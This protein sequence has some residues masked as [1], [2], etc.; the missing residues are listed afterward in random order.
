MELDLVDPIP[1]PIVGP[2]HGRV[3]VGLHSEPQRPST[4]GRPEPVQAFESPRPALPLDRLAENGVL[5]EE[6]IALEWRW[7]VLNLVR[8][9][10]A[11]DQ[12]HGG[13]LAP[14]NT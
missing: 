12:R 13:R 3:L 2:E 8:A 9:V 11:F 5:L 14:Q 6:V 10:P 7:L 4:H 1:V